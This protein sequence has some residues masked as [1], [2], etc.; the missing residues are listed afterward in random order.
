MWQMLME[1]EMKQK[2]KMM[3][4]QEMMK[5]QK[6]MQEHEMQHRW[7]EDQGRRGGDKMEDMLKHVL[8]LQTIMKSVQPAPARQQREEEEEAEGGDMLKKLIML[9]AFLGEDE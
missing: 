7:M 1:A 5:K 2:E 3:Q 9:K 4:E 6:M 8:L